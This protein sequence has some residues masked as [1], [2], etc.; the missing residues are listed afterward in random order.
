MFSGRLQNAK[1]SYNELCVLLSAQLAPLL[2][3]NWNNRLKVLR[4]RLMFGRA[5]FD[6]HEREPPVTLLQFLFT[7]ATSRLLF[8]PLFLVE[9]CNNIKL[10]ALPQRGYNRG[11]QAKLLCAT[12]LRVS[13]DMVDV[14]AY[15]YNVRGGTDV[16]EYLRRTYADQGIHDPPDG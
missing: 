14:A 11:R 6:L 7:V 5:K 3:H 4:K 9:P 15:M 13:P 1:K 8:N 16:I 12:P 10:H 2:E